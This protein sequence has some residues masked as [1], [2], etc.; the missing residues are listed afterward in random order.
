LKIRDV[1][2]YVLK[3]E[4]DPPFSSARTQF[5]CRVVHLVEVRTDEG[6]VGWGEA[7]AGEG[8][9]SANRA[10]IENVLKPL[11]VGEDPFDVEL[12]WH[13]M[14]DACRDHGRR[15]MPVQCISGVDIALW[16]I[17]GKATGRPLYRLLGGKFRDKLTACASALYFR[18]VPDLPKHFGEE[19]AGLADRG[20]KV[21]KVCIGRSPQDD[22]DLA[23]AVRYAMGKDFLL[24]ADASGAYTVREAI[25]LG[26]KLEGLDFMLFEEP[27]A[28]DD[29]GACAEV[30]SAL[31]LPVAAG[32]AE[33]TRWGFRELIERR[34]ADVLR[35][36]I[37]RSGG[38]TEF[39]KIVA[40]ASAAGIPVCPSVRGGEV[41]AAVALHAAAALPDLPGSLS[42]VGPMFECD[43]APDP[44]RDHL[45]V[46]PLDLA[47][48]V[49]KTGGYVSPPER[50]GVGFE[51]N[52]EVLHKHKTE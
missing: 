38:L 52:D 5:R 20:F 7:S 10:L 8:F 51:P 50:P 25:P 37:C 24:T 49:A 9:A 13:K 1:K 45:P 30:R 23:M 46:N 6:L 14:Y 32:S 36:D 33:Y 35:P 2:S 31:D 47:A 40:L 22:L 21:I 43:V 17:I 44:L 27:V 12:I 3:C 4:I 48:E 16:D 41:A 42:P 28:P 18:D 11:V 26:R 29:Y 15:G 34:S 19:A 39:R